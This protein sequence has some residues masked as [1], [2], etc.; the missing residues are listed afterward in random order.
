[1]TD[2]MFDY[3]SLSEVAA[4]LDI[5]PFDLSRY[6]AIQKGGIPNELRFS[7]T[8]IDQMALGLGLQSWW[9]E[10]MQLQD[11][12]RNRLLVRELARRLYNA[13]IE[14]GTRADNLYRG[15]EGN[16]YHFVRRV[17]NAFI[18]S[19][20]LRSFA[21]LTGVSVTFGSRQDLDTVLQQVQN[22]EAF[23]AEITALLS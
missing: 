21:T 19:K 23:P 7:S 2:P 18:K 9:S 8:Q 13:D 17:V 3:Y 16:D 22:G 5:H 4:R 14:Q 10:P 11:D 15:L 6:L 1:M 20:I 12:N